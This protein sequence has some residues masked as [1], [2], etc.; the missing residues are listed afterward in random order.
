MCAIVVGTPPP[1][2][3]SGAAINKCLTA[4]LQ[5][6]TVRAHMRCIS[7]WIGFTKCMATAATLVITWSVFQAPRSASA[8]TLCVM[9]NGTVKARETCKAKETTL[10]SVSIPSGQTG[11]VGPQGPAGPLG[12][13]GPPGQDGNQGPKGAAGTPGER[14]PIGPRGPTLIMRNAAN[15]V[16]G[17]LIGTQRDD[18]TALVARSVGPSTVVL[19]VSAHGASA[20]SYQQATISYESSDCTGTPLLTYTATPLTYRTLDLMTVLYA[21]GSPSLRTVASYE[22]SASTFSEFQCSGKYIPPARCC[23]P[24]FPQSGLYATAASANLDEMDFTPPFRVS[25]E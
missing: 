13:P 5:L 10:Q 12:P 6:H 8:A 7:C 20:S 2:P 4:R 11:P 19:A 17:Q 3:S 14:G 24:G 23:F 1:P 9:R 16:V 22:G 15:S 21:D 25:L 18:G